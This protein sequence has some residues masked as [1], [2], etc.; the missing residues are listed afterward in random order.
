MFTLASEFPLIL[1]GYD[2][3]ELS[4]RGFVLGSASYTVPLDAARRWRLS[5]GGSTARIAFT[6]G[7]PQARKTNSGLDLGLAYHSQDAG[8][9]TAVLVYG[10][11]FDAMRNDHRGSDSVTLTV[12]FDL[13]KM[14]SK[15]DE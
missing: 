7:V 6:A 11:A 13:N 3:G 2:E 1:P 14:V 12:E 5:T 8:S 9:W 15:H 4:A 10:H